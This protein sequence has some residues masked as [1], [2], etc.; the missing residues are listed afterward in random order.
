M[1]KHF[2]DGALLKLLHWSPVRIDWIIYFSY[3]I[4]DYHDIFMGGMYILHFVIKLF[5]FPSITTFF[6][7]W[8]DGV[9]S[10]S[11]INHIYYISRIYIFMRTENAI[12]ILETGLASFSILMKLI[13]ITFR[14]RD[15]LMNTYIDTNGA[16]SSKQPRRH[17]W[18]VGCWVIS[19]CS[20]S[21]PA[22]PDIL[23]DTLRFIFA[24]SPRKMI[25]SIETM[26]TSSPRRRI[27]VN[28]LAVAIASGTHDSSWGN[29]SWLPFQ[30]PRF[31]SQAAIFA[32]KIPIWYHISH[33][34]PEEM[35]TI[36]FALISSWWYIT[37]MMGKDG[38]DASCRPDAIGDDTQVSPPSG[39][40]VMSFRF[41]IF[42][43]VLWNCPLHFIGVHFRSIFPPPHPKYWRFDAPLSR[44]RPVEPK[45]MATL[46]WR[47]DR[48]DIIL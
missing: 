16:A 26:L 28:E 25:F 33:L 4:F 48:R 7:Y 35:L 12:A 39:A 15:Y 32:G 19:K 46:I 29:I 23:Y 40:G 5:L 24:V 30:I 2:P 13:K 47:I 1:Q 20:R 27:I 37:I 17:R 41:L 8:K 21:F 44:H 11:R 45:M 31:R 14:C 38:L 9:L 36:F 10:S 18:V 22:S 6:Y 43:G 3:F 42:R 34:L